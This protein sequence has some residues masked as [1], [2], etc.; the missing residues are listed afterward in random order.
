MNQEFYSKLYKL[1]SD[2][3]NTDNTEN[4]ENAGNTENSNNDNK[5][6][7][8]DNNTN[9]ELCLISSEPLK[10]DHVTLECNHKFNYK[11]IYK[12]VK[13]QQYFSKDYVFPT[14]IDKGVIM[15]PYCRNIQN[16]LLP[17]N[18]KYKDVLW[19]NTLIKTDNNT[20]NNDNKSN[21]KSK[22]KNDLNNQIINGKNTNEKVEICQVILHSGNRKGQM[23]GR[24]KS[25]CQYHNKS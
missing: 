25:K 4:T 11:N 17:H 10:S 18:P 6:N 2:T 20:I 1:I 21:H 16:K 23:C 15:C 14:R 19:V 7:I 22:I 8:K 9:I 5:N 12:E 3:N 13:K 24:N